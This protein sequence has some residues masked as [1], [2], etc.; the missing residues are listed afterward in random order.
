MT[1]VGAGTRDPYR[2]TTLDDLPI[3]PLEMRML[4]GPTDE[5]AFDNPS[6]DFIYPALEPSVYEKVFDF[7]CGCGRVARQLIQQKAQPEEYRGVDLHLGMVRWC[8]NNLTPRAPHFTFEHHDVFNLGFNPGEKPW[9]LPFAVPDRH[10]TL[11]NAHSVFTHLTQ[12]QTEHYLAEVRR[13]L[14]DDGVFRSTWFFFD[15]SD[16]PMLHDF[17]A[18]IYTSEVDLCTAVIYDRDWVVDRARALG[19]TVS[20]VIAPTIHGFQWEVC[21]RPTAQGIVEARFPDDT[22]PKG[23]RT[24]PIGPENPSQVGL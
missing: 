1:E 11:V 4:V 9:V 6:G 8:Q 7:G 2:K 19:L 5:A 20:H 10:F 14:R 22:A 17:Q 13:I 15:K 24:A 12:S 3:P 21:M 16:F 23:R 18:A